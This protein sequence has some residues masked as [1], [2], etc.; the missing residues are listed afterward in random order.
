MTTCWGC[1]EG[2]A[3]QQAHMEQGGCLY[4]GSDELEKIP[5]ANERVM[6]GENPVNFMCSTDL[7][8]GTKG[9]HYYT[10]PANMCVWNDSK[11]NKFMLLRINTT[12]SFELDY[13]IFATEFGTKKKIGTYDHILEGWLIIPTY[14]KYQII[15]I[16]A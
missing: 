10:T 2:L 11:G 4:D 7:L 8:T 5:T 12:K 3:N 16:S 15:I 13:D 6:A 14:A 9:K 1:K